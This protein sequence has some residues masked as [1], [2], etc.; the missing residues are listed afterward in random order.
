MP[1]APVDINNVQLD[2]PDYLTQL[3]QPKGF[4]PVDINKIQLDQPHQ[5]P[6]STVSDQAL[7][8]AT[9]GL[10][11]RAQA[12]LAALLLSGTND[13]GISQNYED[14]R[15]VKSAQMHDEM[16]QSPILSIGSNLLGGL[17]TGGIGTG[18]AAGSAIANSIRSSGT[19]AR[20]AKG[21]LA[22]SV[23]G[24]AYGAGSADYDKSLE[25]GEQGA[26]TGA[27]LGGA[28]PGAGAALSAVKSGAGNAIQ[29]ALARSPDKLQ[30]TSDVLSQAGSDAYQSMRDA[31]AELSRS[32]ISKVTY[33]IGKELS[34]SGLMH[35]ALH[36]DTMSVVDSLNQEAQ[37]GNMSLERLDQYRK[38]LRGVANKNIKIGGNS[39]DA[40]KAG[41]AIDALDNSVNSLGAKD[42]SQGTPEA[43]SALNN[44]R[45]QW[46][47]YKAFD[48]VSNI[49]EQAAGDPNKIKSGF[50]KFV[51]KD[52]N[53]AGFSDD[54]VKALR[55]AAQNSTGE[56][57]IKFL[58][59]FGFDLGSVKGLGKSAALP[60][61]EVALGAAPLAAAGTIAR[62]TGKYIARGKAEKALK[63]IQNRP[64]PSN[65]PVPQNLLNSIQ[66]F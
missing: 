8:G 3:T 13:K 19:A 27:A 31:G 58:G 61:I 26:I 34:D 9:F 25:G 17:A 18:T 38:L 52:K 65:L 41:Q 10:G 30:K 12:G 42:L 28:I 21:A 46:A 5:D 32:G 64:L 35:P 6:F 24:A 60:G 62:Q 45:A 39:E 63:I 33:N 44:A 4:V 47:K 37:A 14:A 48:N 56:R 49:V 29:G 51:S 59:T 2:Q 57:L 54:E 50:Q 22:G 20:I 16:Q 40:F 11:N 1:F 53:L 66:N 55:N 15:N 36:G 7:Q 23:T 43:I